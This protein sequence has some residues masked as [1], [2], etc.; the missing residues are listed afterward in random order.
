[1]IQGEKEEKTPSS[2][3][4]LFIKISSKQICIVTSRLL[5][6]VLYIFIDEVLLS[7]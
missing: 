5:M 7:V 1:M 2:Y 3:P 6:L 4:P